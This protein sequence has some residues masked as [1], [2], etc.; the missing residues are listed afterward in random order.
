MRRRAVG[1]RR[2]PSRDENGEGEM[3]GSTILDLAVGLIFTFLIISLITSTATEAISSASGWRANTLLQ[4]IKDLLNDQNFTGLAL[5]LYNHGLINPQSSGVAEKLADLTT[6]P[7]Y[8]DAKQFATALTE[9]T[10]ISSGV[11]LPVPQDKVDSVVTDLKGKING[12]VTDAQLKQVL[13]GIVD[14][15][16]GDINK[17]NSGIADWFNQSM[18]RVAGAYKRK[19]QLW[20]IIIA[21]ILTIAFNL[22]AVRVAQA[23]WDQP[24]VIKAIGP[25]TIASGT[26]AVDALKQF[27]GLGLPFGWD[28]DAIAYIK[29]MTNGPHWIFAIAGWIITALSTLF[30]APFWFDALQKFVQLRG[31][32]AK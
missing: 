17:I 6:K 5:S 3:F 24:A 23:L 19:T 8:I 21:L 18:Q 4:G 13:N 10:G 20:T 22:D 2:T 12:T 15:A 29:S 1:A 25:L 30:G 26:S 28:N 9:L 32:G 7:S 27:Q 14:R 11:S 16:G 31:A